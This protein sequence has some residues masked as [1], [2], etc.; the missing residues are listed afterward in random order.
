MFA[1]VS[2]LRSEE[3]TSSLL[4]VAS[5]RMQLLRSSKL[6]TMG[7][8]S[9]SKVRMRFFMVSG[10]SSVLPLVLARSVIRSM[11]VWVGQSK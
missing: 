5:M 8:V 3:Y 7:R 2:W 1:A 4:L 10:L 11:R 6:L 9:L